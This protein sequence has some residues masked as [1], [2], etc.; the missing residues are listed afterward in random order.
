MYAVANAL[1][2]D[3]YRESA[4]ALFAEMVA[5]G[6]TT[7]GEFHYVHHRPDGKPY[8]DPNAFG[9]A[10]IEAA[11]I[12]GIRLTL[13]D[14]AYL[15]STV[16]GSPV[17]PEQVRFSDGSIEAWRERT[18]ALAEAAGGNPIV[19][20]GV[21]AHSVRGVASRDLSAVADTADKLGAPLHI[22]V[23]E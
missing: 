9:F 6:I 10:L 21:A 19:R 4:T 15:T 13:L 11:S 8:Q 7:V 16:A 12:A 5:A 3:S 1:T 22:H 14:T 23:S 2:P 18:V 17:L 20:V